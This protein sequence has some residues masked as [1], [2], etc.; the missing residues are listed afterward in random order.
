MCF[1]ISQLLL[2]FVLVDA[3][4]Y[5]AGMT[6]FSQNQPGHVLHFYFEETLS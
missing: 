5:T 3:Y 6:G 1:N 4:F 2:Y